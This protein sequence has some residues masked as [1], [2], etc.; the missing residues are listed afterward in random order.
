MWEFNGGR[1]EDRRIENRNEKREKWER[2]EQ[3]EG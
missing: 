2:K 1:R 3:E